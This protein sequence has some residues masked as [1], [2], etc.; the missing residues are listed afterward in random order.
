MNCAWVQNRLADYSVGM[1]DERTTASV[2]MHVAA[3]SECER[4][5]ETL[6]SV[7]ALVEEYGVRQPPAGLFNAVRNRI[8]SGEIVRERPA[9]WAWFY[10]RP[11]RGLAMGSAMAAVVLGLLAPVSQP[12]ITGLPLNP[13]GVSVTGTASND[14]EH[15]IRQHALSATEGPLTD[16]VAYEALAQLASQEESKRSA[17]V[18]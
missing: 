17:G 11:A 9:W 16:R 2:R 7:V 4:E 8:E 12:V 14:L 13:G 10:S 5:L 6:N 3:C 1:L 18:K 15:S